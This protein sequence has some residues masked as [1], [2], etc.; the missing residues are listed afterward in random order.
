MSGP[1]APRDASSAPVRLIRVHDAAELPLLKSL[2]DS[3]GMPY[4]VE[5]DEALGLFPLGPFGGGFIRE[6]FGATILVPSDRLDEARAL[7]AGV[8][9]AEPFVDEPGGEEA[10]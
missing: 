5:G 9:D 6:A 7:L 8:E 10:P 2:L 3:V 1:R 4:V